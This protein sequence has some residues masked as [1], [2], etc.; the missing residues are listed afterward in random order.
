MVANKRFI[1]HHDE[2]GRVFIY[3]KN[4]AS[5]ILL[6]KSDYERM[7]LS[8]N[9]DLILTNK[10]Q[11]ESNKDSFWIAKKVFYINDYNFNGLL[12]GTFETIIIFISIPLFVF[13]VYQY[14][15]SRIFYELMA[16]IIPYF[17]VGIVVTFPIGL[18]LHEISHAIIA[19]RNGV[20]V[21]EIGIGFRKNLMLYAYTRLIG[22]KYISSR[23]K[24]IKIYFAGIGMNL[25]IASLSFIYLRFTSFGSFFV[26]PLGFMSTLQGFFNLSIFSKSD[27]LSILRVLLGN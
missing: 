1:V 9:Y 2:Q 23:F 26:F 10:F 22:M 20:F 3:D 5:T 27:G 24:K 11:K 19:I 14:S 6:P 12:G 15:V 13:S 7:V 4:T 16:G 8:N 18:L 25:F 17:L 21:P